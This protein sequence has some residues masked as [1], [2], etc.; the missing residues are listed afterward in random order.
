MPTQTFVTHLR[1]LS[2]AHTLAQPQ[3][4]AWLVEANTR[5]ERTLAMRNG[6]QFEE[7][8]FRV[9]IA[10]A[11]ARFGCSAD[12]IATRGVELADGTHTAWSDMQSSVSTRS[13]RA[14]A[15]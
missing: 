14:K 11:L 3:T 15:C 6:T 4:L 1:A 8:Q 7:G 9:R 13:Q 5:A 12:K 10:H 2:P